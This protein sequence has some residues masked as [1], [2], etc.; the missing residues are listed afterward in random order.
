[1]CGVGGLVGEFPSS[2]ITQEG[3]KEIVNY[4]ESVEEII[5]ENSTITRKL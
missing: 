5:S 2:L 4:F 3:R 1:M